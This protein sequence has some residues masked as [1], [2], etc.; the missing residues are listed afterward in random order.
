MTE[1]NQKEETNSTIGWSKGLTFDELRSSAHESIVSGEQNHIRHI[2]YLDAISDCINNCGYVLESYNL[3]SAQERGKNKFGMSKVSSKRNDIIEEPLTVYRRLFCNYYL[4]GEVIEKIR[5]KAK[6]DSLNITIA[7]SYTEKGIQ[8]ILGFETRYELNGKLVNVNQRIGDCY[9]TTYSDNT[10]IKPVTVEI[11]LNYLLPEWLLNLQ[12]IDFI[13]IELQEDPLKSTFIDKH[14]FAYVLGRLSY[15]RG[16]KEEEKEN[17]PAP[18]TFSQIGQLSETLHPI[19]SE[20]HN[21][22][23]SLFDIYVVVCDMVAPKQN[24]SF[25]T[26]I[27]TT[28]SFHKFLLSEL[29]YLRRLPKYEPGQEPPPPVPEDELLRLQKNV[30]NTIRTDMA[31]SMETINGKVDKLFIELWEK[32]VD[33]QKGS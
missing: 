3:F 19:L 14:G 22:K 15:L 23:I 10:R 32:L 11:I 31:Q 17:G 33:E 2:V 1:Y 18:L 4:G 26:I 12:A 6:N 20:S 30:L 9:A 21:G 13:E 25:A 16:C 24:A 7:T 29:N 28:D 5:E 27:S 8:I